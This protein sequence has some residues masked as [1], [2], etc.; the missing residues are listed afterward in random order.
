M[1]TEPETFTIGC[2]AKDG[3]TEIQSVY[4]LTS[5]VKG[6]SFEAEEHSNRHE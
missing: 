5:P 2:R 3:K 1:E 6:S 4:S